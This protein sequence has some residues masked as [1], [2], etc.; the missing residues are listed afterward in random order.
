MH[1]CIRKQYDILSAE[2]AET[3]FD[4]LTHINNSPRA[5]VLTRWSGRVWPGD[6]I[7]PA[8][9][10]GGGGLLSYGDTKEM[11]SVGGLTHRELRGEIMRKI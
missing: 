2:Q 7:P 3:R 6:A 5:R 4:E 1:V 10:P 11:T 9:P 8:G